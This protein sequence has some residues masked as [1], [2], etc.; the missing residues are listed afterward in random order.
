MVLVAAVSIHG[1]L[2]GFQGGGLS[3]LLLELLDS[4]LANGGLCGF[5]A[6][7]LLFKLV[8]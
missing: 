5:G 2:L 8:E 1:S 7:K 3:R 4:F 6:P